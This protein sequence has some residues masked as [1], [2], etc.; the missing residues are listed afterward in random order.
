MKNNK[1]S[2]VALYCKLIGVRLLQA[3]RLVGL[4]AFTVAMVLKG[5]SMINFYIDTKDLPQISDFMILAVAVIAIIVLS[6][7]KEALHDKRSDYLND[8]QHQRMMKQRKAELRIKYADRLAGESI[9]DEPGFEK[10]PDAESGI[11]EILP[12]RKFDVKKITKEDAAELDK[13]IGLGS[14]KEQIKRIRAIIQ[15][16]KENGG[17]A[18][19]V[20]SNIV[21]YGGPGTG[22]TT[23][24]RSIAWLLYD[25]GVLKKPRFTELN[26]LELQG[27]YLGHTPHVV[28]ELFKQGAGGLIFI[29]EA[30]SLAMAAGND[31][32]GY[33]M[34]VVATL[35]THLENNPDGTVVVF[36]G[37][38]RE[39][40]YLFSLNPGLRSRFG[41]SIRFDD[42][43]SAELLDILKLNLEKKGHKL[44]ADAEPL[45]LDIFEHK[46]AICRQ[47]DIPF[48]NGRYARNVSDSLHASHA[49]RYM[50]NRDI[51][52]VITNEDIDPNALINLD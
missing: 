9:A 31:G 52:S 42:F 3:L 29:D 17:E 33:A 6:T 32:G 10:K 43:T 47:Y 38:E 40:N 28:N 49:I 24:A 13:L 39:L 41:L 50:S 51:G 7:L 34:E 27:K 26:A 37:Y 18:S 30:Y 14:V 22:K 12:I 19:S 35:L 20:G 11:G 4:L 2:S 5:W 25:A 21:F 8:L 36:A 23:A 16:E 1:K 15:Y 48:A 44:H 45:M 46:M